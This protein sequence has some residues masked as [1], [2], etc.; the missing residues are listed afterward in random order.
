MASLKASSRTYATPLY[1]AYRMHT[2]S[3]LLCMGKRRYSSHDA[4]QLHLWPVG[5]SIAS[6]GSLATEVN[7]VI[8]VPRQTFT[9]Y[10]S[11]RL[12]RQGISAVHDALPRYCPSSSIAIVGAGRSFACRDRAWCSG[13]G[14]SP[15]RIHTPGYLDAEL[16]WRTEITR[17]TEILSACTIFFAVR[18]VI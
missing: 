13:S 15:A 2:V 14:C 10:T 18:D 12:L 7:L 5:T 6:P 3:L 11:H 8:S 1:V 9:S 4:D 17:L 16:T